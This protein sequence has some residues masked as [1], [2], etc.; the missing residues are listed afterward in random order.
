MSSTSKLLARSSE[1]GRRKQHVRKHER[2]SCPGEQLQVADISI[3]LWSRYL[4][5]VELVVVGVKHQ[6]V[7]GLTLTRY[8][9]RI[10]V[11][12]LTLHLLH[13]LEVQ[14]IY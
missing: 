13:T 11:Y 1:S 8:D 4:E 9:Y 12:K 3:I 14:R 10:S 2:T 5:G 7:L 6:R